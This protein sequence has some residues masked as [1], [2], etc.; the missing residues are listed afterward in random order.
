MIRVVRDSGSR[1]VRVFRGL[2]WGTPRIPRVP[3]PWSAEG[4]R[5][6]SVFRGRGVRVSANSGSRPWSEGIRVI[7]VFRGPG[8]RCPRDPRI[9][10][11][12]GESVR[13]IRVFRDPGVRVSA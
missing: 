10:R 13:V 1:G 8:V 6:I 9:P 2:N 5:V 12:W 4:I 7:S 11:P 3:R